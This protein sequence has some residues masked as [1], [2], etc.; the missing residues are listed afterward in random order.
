VAGDL[1]QNLFSLRRRGVE[2]TAHVRH[3]GGQPNPGG[4]VNWGLGVG[5][6]RTLTSWGYAGNQIRNEIALEMK[7]RGYIGFRED[8]HASRLAREPAKAPCRH[9][10]SDQDQKNPV[11]QAGRSQWPSSFR[12]LPQRQCD[13][14]TRA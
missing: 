11:P 8:P 7:Q 5:I 13:K 6:Q 1:C 2:T 9:R 4:R 14:L 12:L 3:T 10:V